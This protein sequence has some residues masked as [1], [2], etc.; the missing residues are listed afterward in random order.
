[1]NNPNDPLR[2]SALVENRLQEYERITGVRNVDNVI[3][4]IMDCA[5]KTALPRTNHDTKEELSK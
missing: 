5:R 3:K 2:L 1:M 4:M